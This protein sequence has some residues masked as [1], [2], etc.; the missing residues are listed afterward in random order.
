MATTALNSPLQNLVAEYGVFWQS[1]PQFEQIRSERHLVGYEVE[2]IGSHTPDLTDV[3]PAS[4]ACHDVRSVLHAIADLMHREATLS[5]D[6]LTCMIDSHSNS[7]LC[8]PALGNRF[9]VSVSI[10]FFWNGTDGQS[11][12]ADLL[13]KIRAFLDKLGIHQR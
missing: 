8:L 7:I 3:N 1:W 13:N 12:E 4:P 6:S 2:L 10:Y 5:Q 9:A 11:F